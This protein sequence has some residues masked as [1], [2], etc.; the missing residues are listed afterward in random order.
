MLILVL[1]GLG[2]ALAMFPT[3]RCAF[4]HPAAVLINGI[5]GIIVY[6]RHK[7]YNVCGT[8]ELVAYLQFVLPAG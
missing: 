8:G 1:I 2:V 6:I 3:F 7:E 4:F 5:Q